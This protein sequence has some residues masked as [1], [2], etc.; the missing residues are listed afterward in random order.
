MATT[1]PSFFGVFDNTSA[2]ENAIN[3]LHNAN[4]G[5][6]QIY[7][8]GRPSSTGGGFMAGLRN[9][10]SGD[11][12]TSGNG[13]VSQDLSGLG[14][15]DDEANY[16]D[17]QYQAGHAIVGVR[18]SGNDQDVLSLL[19]QNGAQIYST[20]ASGA[21][22]NYATTGNDQ[23]YS[24][25]SGAYNTD[26]TTGGYNTGTT[27]DTTA[28]AYDTNATTDTT[29]NT[30]NTGTTANTY[31]TNTDDT[32][33]QRRLRLREEQLNV[34]KERVQAG[35]VGLHKEVVEEQ[36]NVDVPVSHEEVYVERRPVTD[37]AVNEAPIG[38]GDTI[39]VPVSQDQVNVSKDTVTT[40]EVGIGKRTVEG[41]QRVSD[42]VRREEA[43]LDQQGDVP[44]RDTTND[45]INNH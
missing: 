13:S 37:G 45:D 34:G 7:Y 36:K 28:N 39:N 3:A 29:A 43:R 17:Q 38:E 41:T 40:G 15:P 30:Y 35:Q 20:R 19:Q 27:T 42:T 26:T 24:T 9:F 14:I 11:D 10:F 22:G 32:D 2:A 12:T 8:S 5:D 16:Y 6:N 33:E 23:T 4:I 25:D 44:V 18:T 1:Q 31:D 21:Q